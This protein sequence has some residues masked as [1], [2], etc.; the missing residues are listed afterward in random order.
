MISSRA[1]CVGLGVGLA[2]AVFSG[3]ARADST[4]FDSLTSG[5]TGTS[6]CGTCF[7][8][9]VSNDVNGNAGPLGASFV[10]GATS[11]TNINVQLDM[12][13]GTASISGGGSFLV[14]IANDSSGSPDTTYANAVDVIQSSV[15]D[16]SLGS[17]TTSEYTTTSWTVALGTALAPNTTYW[18][19]AEQTASD[20]N[21]TWWY[22]SATSSDGQS[23]YA[24]GA[25][26]ANSTF[27]PMLMA[28]TD[29]TPAPEPGTLSVL[30]VG[31]LGL[32]LARRRLFGRGEG[33][34]SRRS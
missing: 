2:L 19:M 12:G 6:P 27:G 1:L 32:A 8:Y 17:L 30:G 22:T 18:I 23:S 21:A 26:G 14:F 13:L 20:T 31:L 25:P 16:S 7:A 33:G 29:T 28:V 3:A 4:L 34:S 11:V 5:G 10:T 15:A 9:S 24:F